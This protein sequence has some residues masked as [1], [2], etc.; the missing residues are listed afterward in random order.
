MKTRAQLILSIARTIALI[1]YIG[2]VIH[3]VRIVVPF[4]I[5]F[6]T[7]R[8]P[9]STG[10]NLDHL[11][12]NHNLFPYISLIIFA[13]SIA[14]IQIEIWQMLRKILAE[15]DLS[16]PFTTDVAVMIEKMSSIILSSWIVSYIADFSLNQFAKVVD[17]IHGNPFKTDFQYLFFAGIIYVVAQIFKRGVEL[18]EE[19]DLTV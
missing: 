2:A 5:G 18:Q 6:F 8:F 16:S 14:I 19:S 9:V 7:D 12:D 3:A 10:T 13:I 1:G 15:I 11:R 4:V 17:G